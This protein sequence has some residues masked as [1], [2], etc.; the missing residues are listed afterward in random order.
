[1]INDTISSVTEGKEQGSVRLESHEF[2]TGPGQRAQP[3]CRDGDRASRVCPKSLLTA[4]LMSVLLFRGC[5]LL[6]SSGLALL[7]S[8]DDDTSPSHIC[9]SDT[10][11]IE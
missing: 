8:D 11:H 4:E 3:V 6:S 7:L 1:M 9:L 2:V 5:G 10:L